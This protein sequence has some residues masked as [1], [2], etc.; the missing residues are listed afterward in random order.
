MNE[1]EKPETGDTKTCPMC[2]ETIKAAAIKCKHC[3]SDLA[4]PAGA[5]GD[6]SAGTGAARAKPGASSTPTGD[7]LG[8]LLLVVPLAA[9]STIFAW[10]LTQAP[11]LSFDM[12]TG[13]LLR[14][15]RTIAWWVG[16]GVIVASAVLVT[17]DAMA[18]G[19]TANGDRAKG[20][21]RRPLAFAWGLATLVLWV[22]ALPAW[23]RQ[24]ALYGRRNLVV[25]GVFVGVA[26]AA[27]IVFVQVRIARIAVGDLERMARVECRAPGA[28]NSLDVAADD[29]ERLLE[30][31]RGNGDPSAGVALQ[32]TA[33]NMT[34]Y[35][36]TICWSV[37]IECASSNRSA[38][39]RACQFS[40]ASDQ[41]RHAINTTAFTGRPSCEGPTTTTIR[42]DSVEAKS[43]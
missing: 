7:A 21:K 30:L 39:A 31:S 9:A 40:R 1:S 42:L 25:G 23:T 26:L 13:K 14:D 5:T 4:R 24:R 6:T 38:R 36:A 2:A 43:K 32:C 29:A 10:T 20:E 41:A 12:Y 17:V 33:Q 34:E 16:G 27:A 35:D 28:G 37:S 19:A 15:P 18:A 11:N 8:A 22:V 3:G